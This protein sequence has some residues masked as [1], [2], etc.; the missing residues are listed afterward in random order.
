MEQLQ[1]TMLAHGLMV[2]LVAM[3]CGFHVDVQFVGRHG[4]MAK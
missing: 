1:R 2:V 3:F 4:N